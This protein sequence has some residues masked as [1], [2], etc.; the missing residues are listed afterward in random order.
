MA[1]AASQGS[2]TAMRIL[3]AGSYWPDER[4]GS[5]KV[6]L[7]LG[8]EYRE[9]GHRVDFLLLDSLPRWARSARLSWLLFPVLVLMRVLRARRQRTGY[10]VVDVSGGDGWLL[11]AFRRA[12]KLRSWLVCRSHGWEHEDYRTR[13]TPRSPWRGWIFRMVRLPMVATWAR[14][15]DV[16]VVGS[17]LGRMYA[18]RAGWQPTE[19][20]FAV[21]CGVDHRYL[22]ANSGE[23]GRGILF[24]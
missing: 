20:V 16:I 8:A 10:D 3:L 19:R 15:A 5:P 14:D 22:S 12:L 13:T 23:R 17:S 6:L 4:Q 21:P 7:R 11:G 1:S 9:L 18:V 24:V 2:G